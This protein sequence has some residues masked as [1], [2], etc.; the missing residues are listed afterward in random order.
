MSLL[1]GSD[2]GFWL[3]FQG[4]KGSFWIGSKFGPKVGSGASMLCSGTWTES[5]FTASLLRLVPQKVKV[6]F[7][8]REKET[9]RVLVLVPVPVEGSGW[10]TETGGLTEPLRYITDWIRDEAP[11]S[12]SS[13]SWSS[14]CCRRA[15]CGV[16]KAS[17]HLTCHRCVCVNYGGPEG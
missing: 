14:S 7:S 6:L 16:I 3:W 11:T 8:E 5:W 1:P 4:G 12:S 17:C 2:R 15:C 10:P 13:R 9:Q